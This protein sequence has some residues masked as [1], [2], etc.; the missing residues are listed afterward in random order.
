MSQ[1]PTGNVETIDPRY[2]DAAEAVLCERSLFDFACAAWPIIEPGT[3]FVS[4]WH[5]QAICEH[6]EACTK[7]QI[8]RLIVNVPPRTSKSRLVSVLWPAWV[9][10]TRPET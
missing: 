3:R 5:V 4:S 6:L 9:W 8:R 10:T 2:L 1:R 7:G